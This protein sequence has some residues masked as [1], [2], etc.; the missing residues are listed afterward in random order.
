MRKKTVLV[1]G[2]SG[3][4][5]S[6]IGLSLLASGFQVVGLSRRP[7]V[8]LRDLSGYHEKLTDLEKTE[9][10]PALIREIATDFPPI[11]G[12]VNNSASGSA[13]VLATMHSADI[14]RT[15][16]LNLVAPMILSKHVIRH[17]LAEGRGRIVNITSVVSK[18]GYRGLSVYASTKAGLE[19][20]GKSLAREV[21]PR[22]IT[23]NSVAPGF[24][25]TTMTSGMDAQDIE[26]I[27]RRTSL[28]K[29]VEPNDVASMVC[30]LLGESAAGITGQTISVDAGA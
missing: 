20:F 13:S 27:K 17:M 5:G 6:S 11:Y 29:L 21:G 28:R 9:Q 3:V 8:G 12:L 19:G 4:L 25:K 7:S 18:I 14:N 30:F 16:N 15:L 22:G 2:T 26:R 10:I 1:T 23:V 24:M